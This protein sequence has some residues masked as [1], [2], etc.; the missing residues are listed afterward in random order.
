MRK[1]ACNP[2]SRVRYRSNI[3][4]GNEQDKQLNNA[5]LQQT[6]DNIPPFNDV[7]AEVDRRIAY[8]DVIEI[9][10]HTG[11]GIS[12]NPSRKHTLY[13]GGT[14]IGRGVTVKNLLVTYYGR[15]AIQPQMD[16]V[17]QHACMYGYRQ[18]ELPAIRIYLPQ[19]LV[20]N[21]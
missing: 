15:D 6:F 11:E 19:H 9:N 13:I 12:P 10:S 17:L 20:C 2:G 18:N 8:T 21:V 5:E 16:T 7:I 4:L 14:K 1:S 3:K